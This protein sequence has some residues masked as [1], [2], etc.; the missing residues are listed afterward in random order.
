VKGFSNYFMKQI[1]T[2]LLFAAAAAA[3]TPTVLSV[4]NIVNYQTALCPG[5]DV[6]IFG[7]NFGNA[8]SSASI[9][10]NGV[11]GY[12]FAVTPT[13]I[14]AELP[15]NVPA[16]PAKITVTVGGTSSAPFNINL[17]AYAPVF[18][19]Q[20]SGAGT[21]AGLFLSAANVVITNTGA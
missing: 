1:A 13:Q 18:E 11:P 3:Q 7:A 17:A 20:T 5:L 6:A 19:I 10:I 8:V 9:S 14:N 15:V 2:L 16:G 12:V 4:V 21:G